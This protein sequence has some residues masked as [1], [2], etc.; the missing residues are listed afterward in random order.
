MSC[1]KTHRP[2]RGFTL[3]EVVT[4]LLILGAICATTL[5]VMNRAIATAIDLR[6][7]T[8]AFEVARENMENLLALMTVTEVSDFGTD[9][10]RP[11]IQWDTTVESFNEPAT[12]KMWVHAICTAS[13]VDSAGETQS[14][15]L[16]HWLTGLSDKQAQQ[17]RDQQ[18]KEGEYADLLKAREDMVKEQLAVREY[19]RQKGVDTGPYDK[20]LAEQRRQVKEWI[21]QNEYDPELFKTLMDS[22]RLK[23]LQWLDSIGFNAD[24]YTAWSRAQSSDFWAAIARRAGVSTG[25]SGGSGTGSGSGSGS[26]S[27]AGAGGSGNQPGDSS[28]SSPDNGDSSKAK[29]T[30]KGTKKGSGKGTGSGNGSGGSGSGSSSDS[31]SSN[32]GSGSSDSGNTGSG[33]SQPDPY[34]RPNNYNQWSPDQQKL[35]DELIRRLNGGG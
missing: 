18:K 2:N 13:Y 19:L 17:I 26:G 22:L 3:L 34:Q 28:G 35:W 16:N 23:E 25:S 32:S 4:A 9:P 27:G 8:Q 15:T 29:P 33:E 31:G 24:D 7:R 30:K 11:D 20:I 12:D 1:F 14:V 21:K 6:K 5:A 10:L